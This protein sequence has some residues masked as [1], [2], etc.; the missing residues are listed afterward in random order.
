[1]PKQLLKGSPAFHTLSYLRIF[2]FGLFWDR[3]FYVKRKVESIRE[4]HSSIPRY[5]KL[6]VPMDPAKWRMTEAS[7]WNASSQEWCDESQRK[8]GG[9]YG[10]N[11][12]ISRGRGA[13]NLALLFDVKGMKAVPFESWLKHIGHWPHD[14]SN[15]HHG[16]DRNTRHRKWQKLQA[17]K[18]EKPPKLPNSGKNYMGVAWKHSVVPW[19]LRVCGFLHHVRICACYSWT[20]SNS[21]S[22]ME[23]I[24]VYC[25]F[26][27]LIV[28]SCSQYIM[29]HH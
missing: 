27:D 6:I 24:D 8:H 17:P 7:T 9:R 12:C 5:S 20:F 23:L 4:N 22:L 1:M 19:R 18:S 16:I 10:Y 25:S 15:L 2:I 14:L 3:R 29:V 26:A 28:E 13:L 11:A 21:N